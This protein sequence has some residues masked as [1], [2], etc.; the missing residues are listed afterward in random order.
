MCPGG[1]IPPG[2]TPLYN[3]NRYVTPQRVW[4]LGLVGM[5]TGNI[6]FAQIGLESGVVFEG[7]AGVCERIYR[8]N[9]KLVW[10]RVLFSRELRECVN[11]FTVSIPNE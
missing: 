10:N 1:G 11:V 3:P 9:S 7:T 5:K 4:F 8:F 2:G 6:H